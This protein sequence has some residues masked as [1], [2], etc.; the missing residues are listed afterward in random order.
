MAKILIITMSFPYPLKAGGKIRVY[1]LIKQLSGEYEITLLS[2]AADEEKRYVPELRKYCKGVEIVPLAEGR[3][4]SLYHY[5]RCIVSMCG[6]MPVEMALKDYPVFHRALIH[7]L[8]ERTFDLVQVEFAQML[9]YVLSDGLDK[10]VPEIIWIEHEVLHHR[11]FKRVDANRGAWRWFWQREARLLQEYEVS[12]A[13]KLKNAIAV[14]EEEAICLRSW[15]PMMN[16]AVIPNGV[17]VAY[18]DEVNV[19][20]EAK[21]IIFTGWMRHF[22]NLDSA[23]FLLNDVMPLIIQKIPDV[24]LY[25]VGDAIPDKI[26]SIAE[27]IPQVTLTGFVEDIR[28]FIKRVSA[29]IV[30]LR[31]GGGTHLK[32]LEAMACRT[33]VVTTPVGAE[34]LPIKHG[35]HAW[36]AQDAAGLADGV[37]RLF[38]D[39]ELRVSIVE[40]ARKLVEREFDWAII[41][42]KQKAFYR[43]ILDRS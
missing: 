25:L 18:Y 2:L 27:R 5:M 41:A 15:N 14:S 35:Q 19:K 10:I 38:K 20:R 4:E 9:P 24:R 13:R 6:G 34:G 29:A 21:S 40:E 37:F 39:E 26:R 42:A 22:P 12:A 33:P 28:I 17:D 16:V 1:N 36:I 43:Q 30:P 31:I 8:S 3:M 11:F 23:I 32:V 7:I